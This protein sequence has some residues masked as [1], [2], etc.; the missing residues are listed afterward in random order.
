MFFLGEDQA[1]LN[2]TI[3]FLLKLNDWHITGNYIARFLNFLLFNFFRIF[4]FKLKFILWAR[5]PVYVAVGLTYT[6][7]HEC[8][9]FNQV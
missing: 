2:L 5:F 3:L 9:M 4:Y 7:A 1:Q 6:H 8:C